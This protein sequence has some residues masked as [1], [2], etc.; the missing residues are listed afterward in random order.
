MFLYAGELGK[1]RKQ[2]AD[3]SAANAGIHSTKNTGHD[4]L[5]AMLVKVHW[6]SGDAI[7]EKGT[8]FDYTS[9]SYTSPAV[10]VGAGLDRVT[11]AEGASQKGLRVVHGISDR[12]IGGSHLPMA[13][14]QTIRSSSILSQPTANTS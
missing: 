4:Y 13:L 9:A 6:P 7:L 2:V 14:L 3:A 1:V 10:R 12:G 5:N 11:A 8:F